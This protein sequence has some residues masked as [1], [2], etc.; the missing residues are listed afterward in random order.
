M[1]HARAA[2]DAAHP[3]AG[4]PVGLVQKEDLICGRL[5]GVR[6]SARG[7]GSTVAHEMF[8]PIQGASDQVHRKY[9]NFCRVIHVVTQLHDGHDLLNLIVDLLAEPNRLEA[10]LRTRLNPSKHGRC[11]SMLRRVLESA[12]VLKGRAERVRAR[13]QRLSV[14]GEESQIGNARRAK[15]P[16][17]PT[18]TLLPDSVQRLEVSKVPFTTKFNADR[19][20]RQRPSKLARTASKSWRFE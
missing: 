10:W 12:D 1:E 2:A 18:P 15:Q 17:Q 4:A 9:G 5:N 19:N 11:C 8:G 7:L 20:I 16:E 13:A 6:P 3:R 14:M